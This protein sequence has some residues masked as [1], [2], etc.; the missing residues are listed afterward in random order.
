MNAQHPAGA[1]YSP[2]TSIIQS[3]NSNLAIGVTPQS[4]WKFTIDAR[5][6]TSN[7]QS[8]K[9]LDI[10]T[11]SGEGPLGE[12]IVAQDV[13]RVRKFHLLGSIH[14]FPQDVF[15]IDGSG[16]VTGSS[17]RMQHINDSLRIGLSA[18]NFISLS[19]H[20][21]NWHKPQD[22]QPGAL[23]FGNGG[24]LGLNTTDP[25]TTLHIKTWNVPANTSGKTYGLRI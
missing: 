11:N 18:T 3:P 12:P 25:Q 19:H 21:L 20:G 24:P 2:T 9:G 7:P 13:F 16:A 22:N 6:N 8:F 15:K 10:W 1:F 14:Q 23:F 4:D 5:G 17:Y